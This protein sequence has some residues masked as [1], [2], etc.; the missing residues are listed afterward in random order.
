MA[1]TKQVIKQVL[2]LGVNNLHIK[3]IVFELEFFQKI[4]SSPLKLY[5]YAFLPFPETHDKHSTLDESLSEMHRQLQLELLKTDKPNSFYDFC[6]QTFQRGTSRYGTLT[7]KPFS[8]HGSPNLYNWNTFVPISS[9]QFVKYIPVSHP[10]LALSIVF[11]LAFFQKITSSPL[12]L[13]LYAFLPFH[14]THD[15][16]STLDESLSEMHRQLQLELLKTDKPN[17]FYDF[18]CQTFQRGREVSRRRISRSNKRSQDFYKLSWYQSTSLSE[19]G[20][21]HSTPRLK[22]IC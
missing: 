22:P 3:H 10:S 11:E 15:K 18:C 12:Q 9:F 4:T 13:Y 7:V 8:Q 16:H 17:S 2:V 19:L 1:I 5:P 6:C 21:D 20:L 14:E